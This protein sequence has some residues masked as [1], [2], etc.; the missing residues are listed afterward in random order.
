[1]N[2]YKHHCSDAIYWRGADTN[3]GPMQHS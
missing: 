3:Q 1:M 2:I